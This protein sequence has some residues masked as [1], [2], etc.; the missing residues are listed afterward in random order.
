[1]RGDG[2]R[3]SD[4]DHQ[5]GGSGNYQPEHGQRAGGE[6]ILESDH[7]NERAH[8]L[9]GDGVAAGLSVNSRTGL[10]S[11][12][13]TTA[14]TSTVTL[15]GIAGRRVWRGKVFCKRHVPVVNFGPGEGKRPT[16]SLRGM[17]R[18]SNSPPL[19]LLVARI[20][21]VEDP[22]NGPAGP[23]CPHY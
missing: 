5:P 16:T 20:D 8:Q 17:G 23:V 22:V 10:I 19:E 1:M 11:G 2:H 6:R 4:A 18:S 7:G 13:P 21:S 9:C 15:H 12:T 14:G 3:H